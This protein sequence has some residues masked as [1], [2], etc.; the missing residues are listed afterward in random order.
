MINNF[1]VPAKVLFSRNFNVWTSLSSVFSF[2]FWARVDCS[3]CKAWNETPFHCFSLCC[4]WKRTIKSIVRP[5]DRI[6]IAPN[7][8]CFTYRFSYS[9]KQTLYHGAKCTL[10]T[11]QPSTSMCRL[12]AVK[13]LLY[14]SNVKCM[15]CAPHWYANKSEIS[16]AS[17]CKAGRKRLIDWDDE[18]DEN[19]DKDFCFLLVCNIIS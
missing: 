18:N 5:N 7:S 17:K 3:L 12:R 8:T 6:K 1:P 16:R 11:L 15:I 2:Q 13:Y 14:R 10:L 9:R 4:A 19:F